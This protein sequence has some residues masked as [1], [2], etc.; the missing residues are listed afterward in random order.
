MKKQ[1]DQLQKGTKDQLTMVIF[2]GDLD[3]I[4]AAFIIATGAAA[5]NTKVKLFFTFWGIAALRD[6]NKNIKKEG[7]L[8][9][10]FGFFLPKGDS[11]MKLS[12]LNMGGMGTNL[13]KNIM[14]KN[15]VPDLGE[16]IEMAGDLEVDISVC[17]MSMD[18]MGFKKDEMIDYPNLTYSGV[19]SFFKD[20]QESKVQLFI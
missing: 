14:K 11:S 6:K 13:M 12:R 3:K 7:L 15:R 18:L 20:A 9:K 16:L 5:M 10:L 2:S 8:A 17:E 1:I 4:L 19:A